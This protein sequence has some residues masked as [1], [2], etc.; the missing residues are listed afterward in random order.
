MRSEIEHLKAD[1]ARIEQEI[2]GATGSDDPSTVYRYVKR[3]R[4]S[5]AQEELTGKQARLETLV[6][7]ASQ[8]E[9]ELPEELR[10]PPPP[11]PPWRE[12]RRRLTQVVL[13]G[14]VVAIIAVGGIGGLVAS[15]A[16]SRIGAPPPTPEPPKLVPIE[17]LPEITTRQ[18]LV[19]GETFLTREVVVNYTGGVAILSGEPPPDGQFWID[20]TI[21]LTVRRPDG[22]TVTWRRDF[23]SEC[24]A[25]RPLP[26]QDISELFLPGRNVVLISLMDSCGAFVGSSG[27][28]S[29]S[30][31]P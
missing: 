7:E 27:R 1:I 22:S 2:A 21:V 13:V 16:L 31:Q 25:N 6:A 17:F 9:A 3:L 5:M 15:G 14:A 28:V 30:L 4:T 24:L 10:G 12:P 29:L 26:P 18:A 8:L 19:R 11:P 20:D 23:N